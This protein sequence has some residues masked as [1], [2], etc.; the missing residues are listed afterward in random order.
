MRLDFS[1]LKKGRNLLAF[2]CGVDSSAL[3]FLLKN[4]GICFDVAMVDYGIRKQS[5]LEVSRAQ[6]LCFLDSKKFFLHKSKRILSDFENNA[7]A[8]RYAFFETIIKQNGYD[9]LILAHQLN[10]ALEWFLM[11]FCK[12]T[13]IFNCI[14]EKSYRKNDS[15]NIVRPLLEVSRAEILAYLQ[16]NNIFYFNDFSNTSLK[17]KRNY[18]RANFSNRLIDEFKSGILFS[19]EQLRHNPL[20]EI[21]QNL[22]VFS[23]SAGKFCV[24]K[25]NEFYLLEQIQKASKLCGILLSKG[26]ILEIKRVRDS[27]FSLFLQGKI[28]IERSGDLIFIAYLYENVDL[29][30]SKKMREFYRFLRIPK[31][32]R[33]AL[34]LARISNQSQA[35]LD[36][37]KTLNKE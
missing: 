5:A 11:Q 4:G 28:S 27:N 2:S 3:Y 26:Q 14:M 35:I 37:I 19:L 12:G 21:L 23:L 10:D 6:N 15:Y 22:Q 20:N 16:K 1:E 31:K 33:K 8:E 7:R 24:F 29:I 17:Y 36:K 32:F 34:E 25:I 9:N 30:M 18:F 13:S